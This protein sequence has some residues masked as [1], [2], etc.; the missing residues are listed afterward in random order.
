VSIPFI[1][2]VCLSTVPSTPN[3]VGLVRAT[4]TTLELEIEK[5]A[6]INGASLTD[7][8]L[9]FAHAYFG[10]WERLDYDMNVRRKLLTGLEPGMTY[11]VRVRAWNRIG[12]SQYSDISNFETLALRES[13]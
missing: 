5:P 10:P 13:S 11:F 2:F 1:L 6:T 3:K 12:P 7:I 8:D 4:A 9:E